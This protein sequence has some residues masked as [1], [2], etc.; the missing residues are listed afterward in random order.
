[1]E[2]SLKKEPVVPASNFVATVA[3]NVDNEK[4]ADDGFR[5]FIRNTLPIVIYEGNGDANNG[6][7]KRRFL[8][9]IQD[10]ACNSSGV[11]RIIGLS[12][13]TDFLRGLF[14]ELYIELK[15]E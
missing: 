6:Y 10:R 1:M 5:E 11:I 9:T 3:A 12:H 2:K 13:L 4:L 15:K 14:P 7:E 8:E